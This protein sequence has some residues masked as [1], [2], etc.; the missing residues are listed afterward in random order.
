MVVHETHNLIGY[1]DGGLK[2]DQRARVERH[3]ENCAACRQELAHLR[4]ARH[5]LEAAG[6]AVPVPPYDNALWS[7]VHAQIARP[8]PA[9]R[10]H[11]RW[12][13][14]L[15]AASAVLGITA[16]LMVS[17]GGG[18]TPPAAPQMARAPRAAQR[19]ER[20]PQR[21][22]PVVSAV[23]PRPATP[24]PPPVAPGPL[25]ANR[26]DTA[27]DRAMPA[28][29]PTAATRRNAPTAMVAPPAPRKAN[30]SEG[31]AQRTGPR[32]FT[33]SAPSPVLPRNNYAFAPPATSATASPPPPGAAGG[34]AESASPLA[35][36]RAP[37]ADALGV[38]AADR[39]P[40]EKAEATEQRAEKAAARA[41][42]NAAPS[43]VPPPPHAMAALKTATPENDASGTARDARQAAVAR[44]DLAVK[45]KDDV[46]ALKEYKAALDLGR[47]AAVLAKLGGVYERTGKPED[48]RKA[49][50]D[51]LV[52][53]PSH[54]EARAGLARLKDR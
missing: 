3:L 32:L 50:Q 44:G 33:R 27:P 39:V 31:A 51:A 9:P 36:G 17:D 2:P 34:V 15:G 29:V 48:A 24:V 28:P 7:R 22:A 54:A 52:L 45:V 1:L 43:P 18:N 42:R 47:D 46:T 13:L 37:L 40:T 16:A 41:T 20:A 5:A 4:A 30:A 10:V 26:L 53:S 11:P 23:P 8:H 6:H 14:A 35:A 21:P 38:G 12:G 49:Y 19:A 25:A